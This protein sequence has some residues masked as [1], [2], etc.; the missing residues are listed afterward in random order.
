MGINSKRCLKILFVTTD[1]YPY[2]GTTS[3]LIK[4]LVFD[5]GLIENNQIGVLSLCNN[6]SLKNFEIEN[7]VKIYRTLSYGGITGEKF[8]QELDNHNMFEKILPLT[9]K[10]LWWLYEKSGSESRLFRPNNV[11]RLKQALERIINGKY[12]VVVPISGNYDAVIAVLLSNISAKKVFWQVDPCSTNLTR[13]KREKK[14]SERIEK[15]IIDNFDAVLTDEIYYKELL[16]IYGNSIANKCHIF[17]MPLIDVTN[18]INKRESYNKEEINCVF[19]GLIYLGIRDPGYT[20]KLFNELGKGGKIK[21]HL[22]GPERKD[23]PYECSDA[24][25]FHRKVNMDE[26]KQIIQNADFLVN[27]GNKMSNQIPSKIYE[28]ISTGLPIIN[29]YKNSNCP[30]LKLVEKYTNSISVLEDFD[31]FDS[32]LKCLD[33][34][35]KLHLNK[36]IDNKII[37]KY[38]YYYFPQN[39]SKEF[40]TYLNSII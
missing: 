40:S 3:N 34:F 20:I 6:Y 7:G 23:V 4:K 13:L 2:F 17:H 33:D 26:A 21:L 15:S 30:S 18:S 11:F 36:Y 38:Y 16:N 37:E 25:V 8:W 24:I 19:T 10:T 31:M 22:Y 29:I 35:I 28:Y 27:I 14:L 1:E 5:G 32:Q 39:V 12:D 9:E